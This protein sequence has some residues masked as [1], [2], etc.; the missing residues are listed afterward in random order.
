MATVERWQLEGAALVACRLRLRL[1]LQLQRLR[2]VA[3]VRVANGI[4]FDHSGKYAAVAPF[5][6]SSP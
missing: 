5:A 1:S 3:N 2:L 4:R 6:Y